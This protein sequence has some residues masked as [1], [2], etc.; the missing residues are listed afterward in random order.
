M[1]MHVCVCVCV[2]VCLCGKS[3]CFKEFRDLKHGCVCLSAYANR[4]WEEK[5]NNYQGDNCEDS[6]LRTLIP[7]PAVISDHSNPECCLAPTLRKDLFRDSGLPSGHTL[8]LFQRAL[9]THKSNTPP[10]LTMHVTSIQM[11]RPVLEDVVSHQAPL[12]QNPK[13]RGAGRT[14]ES[15]Q[16]LQHG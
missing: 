4:Q 10:P 12:G 3:R 11:G 9:C 16:T 8:F 2:C 15:K 5:E 7:L 1:C 6:H 13:S 14:L